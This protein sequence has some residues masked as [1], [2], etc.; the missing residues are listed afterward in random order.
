MFGSLPRFVSHEL[1]EVAILLQMRNKTS[2][3]QTILLERIPSQYLL[4]RSTATVIRELVDLERT[5]V[6]LFNCIVLFCYNYSIHCWTLKGD[7]IYTGRRSSFA[8]TVP[9]PELTS[10]RIFNCFATTSTKL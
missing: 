2:D 6:R 4:F 3:N 7:Y 9:D 1:L 5:F 8:S 10:A